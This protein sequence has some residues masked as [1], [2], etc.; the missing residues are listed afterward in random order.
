MKKVVLMTLVTFL[1]I[2]VQ[3]VAQTNHPLLDSFDDYL[4]KLNSSEFNLAWIQLGPV[5]N[6]ARVESI[7]GV[8]GDP[9]TMYCAF[10]SGNLWKT[11]DM[12]LSWD[13]IFENQ[14]VLGI[15]DIAVSQSDPETIWLGSGESL[16]K[17][18]N[19]TMPGAGIYRSR[20][21]GD[22]WENRGLIN[23][24]H[25]GEIIV[26]PENP[27]IVYVAA[28]GQLWSTNHERGVFMTRD[29]GEN[30]EHVI[31]ISDKIGA[32]D[33]VLA[34]SDPNVVYASMWENNPGVSGKGSTVYKTSDGG[35][36][37]AEVSSGLPKGKAT[38]RIG[39]AVSYSDPDKVYA[40]VDNLNREK[41][42]AAE[43]YL[44]LNGG[45]LWERTH[46]DDLLIF[47][48]IGWYFAD[49]YVNPL[50]DNEIYT[51]GV[52]VARSS[53]GGK[54][55]TNLGGDIYHLVPNQATP[56]HLDMCEM[57]ID[58]SNP[59][60][61]LLATDGGLYQSYNR[62]E[63]WLHHNNIPA[64]EF[65]DISV[66]NQLPYKV[67]GGTQDDASVYGPSKEWNPLYPDAWNYVWLD[68]WAGGDGCVTFADPDNPDI[69]YFSSQNGNREHRQDTKI[70]ACKLFPE[71]A[72]LPPLEYMVQNKHGS[73]KFG[74]QVKSN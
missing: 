43:V 45:E 8:A 63:S 42:K 68:A 29:G 41:D 40:L 58:P 35:E 56:L 61:L 62:G 17:A 73:T 6:S 52:R 18:R 28:L 22:T 70:T 10:G 31:Y 74:D 1:V 38:G 50:N 47:P 71:K 23:T 33:I 25:I 55:F 39:L 32:I 7:Q 13:A 26:H 11:I 53:D 19:F 44:S 3:I 24:W 65:Y 16:K 27:D 46:K 21:G 5:M 72:G 2:P 14:A 69:V 30:W 67:Y 48:G 64:G 49:I 66:D 9:A 37:W 4:E 15:G 59:S 54:T 60:R 36:N 57:W 20:D 12:G 34:P 51:L